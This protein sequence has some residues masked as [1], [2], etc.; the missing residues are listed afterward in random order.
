[1]KIRI[2]LNKLLVALYLL[3]VPTLAACG[4]LESSAAQMERNDVVASR[5]GLFGTEVGENDSS[6]SGT[7]P[8]SLP[9]MSIYTNKTYRF[10]FEYPPSW[11]LTEGDHGVVLT[12]D[13]NILTIHFRRSDDSD[14]DPYFGRT[15]IG[16][17]DLIYAGKIEFLGQMIPIEI[18][19]YSQKSKAV[20]YN[21]TSLIECG[22]LVFSI[23][24]EDLESEYQEVNLPDEIISETNQIVESF[25]RRGVEAG[26]AAPIGASGL[27]AHL[28]VQGPIQQGSGEPIMV[29][30]LLENHAQEPLY[31]LKWY[32][33]LE[34]IAGDIFMVFY[35]GKALPY[36]GILASRGN[37]KP[38]SYIM[39]EPG[40][41]VTT[42]VD[43]SKVFDFSHQGTYT[44]KFRSPQ[45]SNVAYSEAGMATTLDELGPVRIPS[46]EIKLE[47]VASETSGGLPFRR[48][49]EEAGEMISASLPVK[50]PGLMAGPQLT[51]LEATTEEI[52]EQLGAQVFVVTEG[53]FQNE[54]FLIRNE[55]VIQLGAAAGGQGLTSLAVSDLDQDGQT[56][57]LF[58]Y[59]AALGPRFG[60]GTQTRIGMFVPSFDQLHTIDADFAYLG[61]AGL[62][63]ENPA[64]VMLAI[65]EPKGTATVLYYLDNLGQLAI[66]KSETKLS[67]VFKVDPNLSPDLMQNILVNG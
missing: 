32:T 42:E 55:Q 43:I 38:D 22:E 12:R 11:S 28:E 27:E 26:S 9:G 23:T 30:F 57:L 66:E 61:I 60:A 3:A 36:E 31:L 48:T 25:L 35:N 29:S 10:T 40:K 46:N 41:G 5:T 8:T 13:K 67:L 59:V 14:I 21:G 18:L 52:W 39:I 37:P 19:Q 62:K 51:F 16:A 54:A 44:I 49:T 58:S 7:E 56:E 53:I 1:M 45:I 47:V 6:G 64:T 4:T 15:G 33:P 50:K 24:L 2:N 17:G 63:T 20:F 65:I 34:G